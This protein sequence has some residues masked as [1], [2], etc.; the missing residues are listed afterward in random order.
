MLKILITR[1][2]NRLCNQKS[3]MPG[4]KCLSSK[5]KNIRGVNKE[6][7]RKFKSRPKISNK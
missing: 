1:V 2:Y 3:T 4:E 6:E 7:I 5:N